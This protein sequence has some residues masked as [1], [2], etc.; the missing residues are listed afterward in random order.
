MS[1]SY[2]IYFIVS[3]FYISSKPLK[4]VF[5]TKFNE[6]DLNKDNIMNMLINNYIITNIS[7][8]SNNE[9]FEMSIKLQNDSTFI[10]SDSC[11]QNIYAKKFKEN[12][13]ET[14]EKILEKKK[15]YT[16]AFEFATLSKDNIIL[17][18]EKDQIIK[19]NDFKFM[20]AN[21]L[22]Y[23]TLK[24]MSGTIGL[25]LTNKEDDPKCTD[26]IRQL[27]E[28]IDSEV[29]ILDYQNNYNGILYIG[30][31]FH[32]FNEKYSELDLIKMKSG[33]K[34]SQVKSWEINIDKII[35]TY[36]NNKKNQNELIQN[37]TYL[38]LYYE[39]GVISAPQ[40]YHDYIITNFFEKYL[41]SNICQEILKFDEFSIFDKYKYIK[42]NKSDFDQK[43]FPELSFFNSESNFTFTL[44]YENLFYEF[45]NIIYCLIIFPNYP[46]DV[47]YWYV[48]KPFFL[49]YK[50]FMDKD[51]KVIGLYEKEK[52]NEK[53]KEK[54]KEYKKKD[55]TKFNIIYIVIIALL[56]IIVIGILFYFLI[57]KKNRKKR[58]N[59]LED[60]VDYTPY[61][62]E[63]PKENIN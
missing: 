43:L 2:I 4:L 9:T 54:E 3:I 29:F 15:Y 13:S 38:R 19:I 31:Y 25:I 49:K 55:D 21:N 30:N 51:N 12:L 32:E 39:I 42:C 40:I 50:L 56:I 35:T 46:I 8:G 62:E 24:D 63:N 52:E 61:S 20:L 28:T 26:F 11:P 16:Y 22:W 58:A 36:K 37:D 53:E 23:D 41:N 7:F 60:N 33:N 10:L 57:I 48:G 47:K 17:Y 59:E 18:S 44:N 5:K 1:F 6:K 14:Y 27:N 45:D 34:K